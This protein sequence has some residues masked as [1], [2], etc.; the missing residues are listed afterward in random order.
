M[1]LW[2]ILEIEVA[3]YYFAQQ[4]QIVLI[5]ASTSPGT[6]WVAV[7]NLQSAINTARSA[8]YRLRLEREVEIR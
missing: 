8:P 7:A 2:H 3:L 5:D 6:G 1:V 4:A